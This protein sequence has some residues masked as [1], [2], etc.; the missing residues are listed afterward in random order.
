MARPQITKPS[1][2][3]TLSRIPGKPNLVGPVE[4]EIVDLLKEQDFKIVGGL[5]Q[6]DYTATHNI[7]ASVVTGTIA[8]ETAKFVFAE[9]PHAQ[10]AGSPKQ[11]IV[12]LI[13][14]TAGTPTDNEFDSKK[15]TVIG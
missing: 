1:V 8:Q 5:F 14:L 2:N 4:G 10:V 11:V 15:F 3:G 9:M 13:P 12:W 6:K 7:P